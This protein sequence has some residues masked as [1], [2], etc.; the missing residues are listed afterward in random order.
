MNTAIIFI[1]NP[2]TSEHIC[3]ASVKIANEPDKI[4]PKISATIKNKQT[5]RTIV[6]FFIAFLPISNFLLK[7]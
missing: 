6:S 1:K 2:A 7:A 3:A 5:L 4:P